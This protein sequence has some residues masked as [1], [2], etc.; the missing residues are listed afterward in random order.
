MSDRQ[1][2]NNTNK[3]TGTRSAW[4][5]L[6]INKILDQLDA[7][8]AGLDNEQARRRLSV[9][10]PN[11]IGQQ[12]ETSPWKILLN[13]FLSPLIYVL[14]AAL[15][16]TLAIQSW[17]DAIVIG[18]VLIINS[19]I[20]FLQEYKAET[21]VHSLIEMVSPKA[22]VK[23]DGQVQSI[24]SD[25]LVPGDVVILS[26]GNMVPAD[27]RLLDAKRLQIN[28]AAL[29]GESVPASKSQAAMTDA[30]DNLPPA[31]QT[32]MAF[33]G[34][35]VTAGRGEG[36]VVATGTDTQIGQIAEQVRSAGQ[37]QTPLQNRMDRLAKWIAAIILVVCVIAFAVG[38]LL[39][40]S[41]EEM[42]LTA[43]AL[44]VAAMPAGL[45][46]VMTVALAIGV[47]RMARRNAI[48]RHLPAVETLGSTTA[49]FS[50]KTGTLTQ[51]RMTVEQ[52]FAGQTRYH[53]SGNPQEPHGRLQ[54]EDG[55]AV[56]LQPDLDSP[57]FCTLLVGLLNNEAELMEPPSADPNDNSKKESQ[58]EPA[59]EQ[60]HG[61]PMEL[62]LLIA[63]RKAGL[64]KEDL[65]Q[66]YQQVDEIPFET[67]RKFSATIHE[68]REHQEKL[69]LVK[70]AP[71]VIL[72][73]SR[74][75]LTQEQ[76]ADDLDDDQVRRQIEQLTSQ[77]LRVLAMAIGRGEEAARAI[78]E[79][80]PHDM[81][82]VGLQ[83]M[84]DPP[85][86][87]AIEAID[88]CHEAGIRV[89]MITGDHA[90]TAGAIA[91]QVHLD[92]PHSADSP[93]Y[94]DDWPK[95][96]SG[97]ELNGATDEEIDRILGDTNVYAR[98]TPD[99]KLR[100][101]RQLKNRGDIVAVTGDGVNDA[102]A[103][104]DAD[105]GAAMGQMGTDVAKEASDMVITDDNFSSVYA[106][107]EEGRTAFRN[108]RMA[109]FFLLS[110]GAAD[111]LII[112]TAL[113]VGWPLPLLPAQLL[114][115]NVVTNGIQDV[116]L[117]FEPGEKALY[118]RSPR[119]PNEG[120]LDQRLLER[121]VLV[122]IWLAVGTL[123]IFYWHYSQGRDLVYTRTAALSTLV[124][125]Q[126]VHVFNCRS[127]D[128]SIFRKNLLGNKVL[129]VGVIVSLMVH[130]AGLYIP[131]TQT[132]LR[133]TPLDGWTWLMIVLVAASA[134]IVNELHKLWRPR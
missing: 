111:V 89:A 103:L 50:D 31:D 62:A 46:V 81:I 67:E 20:G 22:R 80:N 27:L 102:P 60:A 96:C 61:D 104:K 47:K 6:D 112:M 45:P 131:W 18:A 133:F 126:M 117:A 5:R 98:V 29:T 4:H 119:P 66:R 83:G 8:R 107:V 128:V 79:E 17:A 68:S 7:D 100:L 72:A 44:A 108:I 132:L 92:R 69:V 121:L 87:E 57:L 65:S 116:A 114:W 39:G 3:A 15:V 28:E 115:C 21:A 129:F 124:L 33:M 88:R 40:F 10:G 76:Q 95:V 122:G 25:R 64:D 78:R 86:Q 93:S 14:L 127:E 91:K 77:G 85:R 51:N 32:N 84:K 30:D 74:Q 37:E 1:N 130:V 42:F 36:L 54:R 71:E 63:A 97:Q 106:A 49:I 9:H 105:L 118:R 24:E 82:F 58:D 59:S 53:L 120:I 16:V 90:R 34:T 41:I 110:T 19:T 99:Q 101:I 23:R 134:I 35:A 43:V 125:F 70:G 73:M 2:G 12:E 52:L 109:T 55:Q 123:A 38:L 94:V 11:S 113:V 75:G 26:E 56:E 48:I 13:Q